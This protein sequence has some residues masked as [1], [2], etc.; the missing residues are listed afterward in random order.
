MLKDKYLDH[1][2]KQYV[3]KAEKFNEKDIDDK[4]LEFACRQLPKI[5]LNSIIK[6]I[7]KTLGQELE[8]KTPKKVVSIGIGRKRRRKRTIMKLSEEDYKTH[9]QGVRQGLNDP[10]LWSKELQVILSCSKSLNQKYLQIQKD[11]LEKEIKKKSKNSEFLKNLSNFEKIFKLTEKEKE[12]ITFLYLLEIES[13][14]E[15]Y[16]STHLDLT[17]LNKSMKYFCTF[18]EIKPPELKRMFSKNSTIIKSGVISKS[19]NI[20]SIADNIIGYLGGIHTNSIEEDYVKQMNLEE[21]IPLDYHNLNSETKKTL[22]NL[23][24]AK[25][26]CNIMF[27][28]HPGTG[29]T[30]LA[31]ALAKKVKKSVFFINQSD[32]DGEGN[33]EFRKQAIV[34][35]QNIIKNQDSIIVVD[36]CDKIL[37]IYDGIWKF[38]SDESNDKKAWINELLENA[39][40]KII[41]ISN[42][43]DGIDDSTK[44]RFSYSIEFHPLNY[45]QRKRVWETQVQKLKIDF[46][47][48]DEISTMAKTFSVNSGGISL[49]LKDVNGMSNLRTKEDKIE[50]LKSLLSQHQILSSNQKIDLTKKSSKYSLEAINSDYPLQELLAYTDQFYQKMNL[51]QEKG[52][53]NIALLLQ[54][55]PGTGKTE[56]VKHLTE[57]VG[58]ELTIKRASDIRSKWYGES[59][60][61]IAKCF[62]D[63]QKDGSIL[64]F[65]EADSFFGSRETESS[66]HAEETNEFLT[67]MENFQGVL[68]CATNFTQK[69]DQASMRRFNFKVK[70][71]YLTNEAK[72]L[73]FERYFSALTD[74]VNIERLES[75]RGLTPGDFKV[76][77][78]KNAFFP[79][80]TSDEIL[81]E[82]ENEVSYKKDFVKKVGLK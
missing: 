25:H 64:F 43:I 60:K 47:N 16:F 18:F 54:G 37:N 38:E 61:N 29:K 53:Y 58:R 6:E 73:L 40:H 24:T 36:E 8:Q 41:W 57:S 44:R 51:F 4:Y 59:V 26:G 76:V 3:L 22:T 69:L 2:K 23:L 33:L 20:I 67:Q 45:S 68:I 75:I 5:S 80:K 55:P 27:Y 74:Q 15:D 31:K 35:T 30:E 78:Q 39:S 70:F 21:V 19:E 46:L 49:A 11:L 62:K 9:M 65:D 71:D 66:Y 79:N 77:Y 50:I 28:G 13:D 48:E 72:K 42:K 63:A 52:I 34:A 14:M 17:N 56:F 82:L 12:I 1:C 10:Y 7:D 81:T 32:E